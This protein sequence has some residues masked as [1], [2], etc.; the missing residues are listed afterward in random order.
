MIVTIGATKGGVGKTTIALQLALA[1]TLAGSSVLLVD[2]DRQ[3][4]ALTAVAMRSEASRAP[5][6]ACVHYP[7]ERVLQ[8]Q[9]QQQA[10]HYDDVIIDVGGRDSAALRRALLI[11]DL[12]VVPVQPRSVDV[13][14][15]AD[16]AGLVDRAQEERAE[17]GRP[18]LRTCAV[19][20]MAD[21]GASSDNAAAVD[22]LS[23]HSQFAWIDAPIRRRKA[24]ANATG[25]GYAVSEMTPRD[26]KAC[27]EVA[28]LVRNVFTIADDLHTNPKEMA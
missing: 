25:L 28:E 13:W 3:A 23:E 27:E 22:A 11:S 9:V 15:F 5:G 20:S 2:G 19:L 6:I 4:S 12:I 17:R 8:A 1:R 18:P 26:P 7:E 21:P 24:Y 10:P 16:I 14:A